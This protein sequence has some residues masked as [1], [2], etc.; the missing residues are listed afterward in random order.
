MT[1]LNKLPRCSLCGWSPIWNHVHVASYGVAQVSLGG[2]ISRLDASGVL[3]INEAELCCHHSRA[4]T[5]V[6]GLLPQ[7]LDLRI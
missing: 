3:H 7:Q 5:A 6:L 4:K 2:R 1:S